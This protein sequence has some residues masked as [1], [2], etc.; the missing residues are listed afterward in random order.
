MEQPKSNDAA[1]RASGS[2][3]R[4]VSLR[5]L[6]PQPD[7]THVTCLPGGYVLIN[8]TPT[9]AKIVELYAAECLRL[10]PPEI[11]AECQQ[12]NT[13]ASNTGLKTEG[14]KNE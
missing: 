3:E 2:L 8:A 12:A 5:E 4:V 9:E 7:G 14:A 11:I 6:K 13:K 10:K 1:G